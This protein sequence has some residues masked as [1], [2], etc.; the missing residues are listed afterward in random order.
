LQAA[1]HNY[2]SRLVKLEN[3]RRNSSSPL[4][5]LDDGPENEITSAA[6]DDHTVAHELGIL[7]CDR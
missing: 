4:G 7:C 6:I 5:L 3:T 2:S 1:C